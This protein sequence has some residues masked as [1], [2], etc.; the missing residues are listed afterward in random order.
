MLRIF[1]S[2]LFRIF[3][4]AA[5]LRVQLWNAEFSQVS[6]RRQ[7]HPAQPAL[8]YPGS[9]HQVQS[10]VSPEVK[11]NEPNER[12]RIGSRAVSFCQWLAEFLFGN[13]FRLFCHKSPVFK[14]RC[15]VDQHL[16]LFFCCRSHPDFQTRIYG[17][18]LYY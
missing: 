5:S 12:L 7:R 17:S 11:V 1:G 3:S 10:S 16:S 14:F 13:L 4:C 8:A 15:F 9:R 2:S 18:H 6:S